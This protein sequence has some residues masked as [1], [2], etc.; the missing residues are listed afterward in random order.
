MLYQVLNR[1][2]GPVERCCYYCTKRRVGG[3]KPL[4]LAPYYPCSSPFFALNLH[5]QNEYTL[6]Q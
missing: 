1:D 2:A 6:I 5:Q 3:T 4:F